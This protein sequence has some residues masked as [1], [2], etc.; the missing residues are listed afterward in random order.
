MNIVVSDEEDNYGGHEITNLDNGKTTTL[1]HGSG[2]NAQWVIEDK[3]DKYICH[4]GYDTMD[5]AGY[6][7][8]WIDFTL[9]IPKKNPQDYRLQFHTDYLGWY[10][11]YKYALRDYLEYIFTDMVLD[12]ED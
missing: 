3:G 11:I 9:T 6:Y 1:P 4:N 5:E 2:I 7:D 10:R 12:L 8:M